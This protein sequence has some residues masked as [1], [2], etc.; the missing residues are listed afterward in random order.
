MATKPGEIVKSIVNNKTKV[1]PEFIAE[2][3][4]IIENGQKAID[5]MNKQIKALIAKHEAD[6]C[7]SSKTIVKK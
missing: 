7:C 4:Q 2:L 5:E 1:P 6:A 3:K